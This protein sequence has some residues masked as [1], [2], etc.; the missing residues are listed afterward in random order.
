MI[1]PEGWTWF[2]M[3]NINIW[4]HHSMVAKDR[5]SPKK[6]SAE[7]V[8]MSP[9]TN[10]ESPT[11]AMGRA[12]ITDASHPPV[13]F[14]SRIWASKMTGSLDPI[15]NQGFPGDYSDLYA[16]LEWGDTAMVFSFPSKPPTADQTLQASPFQNGDCCKCYVEQSSF[17]HEP[18]PTPWIKNMPTPNPKVTRF[19][20][21]LWPMGL[22]SQ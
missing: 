1:I 9:T 11:C 6:L 2:F 20:A 10:R 19:S 12:P 13:F 8:S 21:F 15:L 18:I 4:N 16:I 17:N 22:T 7:P 14:R 3:L 5:E